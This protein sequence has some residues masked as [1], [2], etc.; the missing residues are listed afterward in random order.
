MLPPS[1]V[2]YNPEDNDMDLH[3]HENVKSCFI[4]CNKI[5]LAVLHQLVLCIYIKVKGKVVPVL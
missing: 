2:C 4:S 3:Y 5:V 1:L